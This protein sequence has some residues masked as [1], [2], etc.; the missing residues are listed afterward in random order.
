M[1]HI[2]LV[3]TSHIAEE[4]LRTVERVISRERPDCVAVELDINRFMA[5][6]QGESS[7]W[8]ILRQLGPWTFAMFFVMKSMQ[9]WLEK[10]SG[11]MP[12]SDM[13]KAV[14]VAEREGVHVEFIDRD[15]GVTLG[16]I[17]RISWR[18]R[19]RL[20]LF[21]VKGLTVDSLLARM[22]RK[23]RVEIDFR[24]VPKKELVRDMLRIMEKEFPGMYRVLVTERNL[25]MARRLARLSH[26]YE[27][28]VAVVGAAHASGIQELMGKKRI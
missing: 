19:M 26:G 11:I 24:K 14:R 17:G 23:E 5:L 4:S 25:Y 28:I 20:V 6:E 27:K 8:H 13:F 9:S 10:K 16:R 12:G 21:L 15:I 18:E 22:G 2:I 7:S 1:S 3:P